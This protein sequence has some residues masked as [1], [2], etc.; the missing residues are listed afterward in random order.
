MD[1]SEEYH[2]II[3]ILYLR[4]FGGV[5]VSS[6]V[7]SLIGSQSYWFHHLWKKDVISS[8]FKVVGYSEIDAI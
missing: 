1:I 8:Y 4:K 2:I 5:L 6:S 3:I 7:E